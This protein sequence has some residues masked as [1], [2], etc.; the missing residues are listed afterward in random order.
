M[1]A[2]LAHLFFGLAPAQAGPP[3]RGVETRGAVLYSAI[4]YANP[5]VRWKRAQLQLEPRQLPQPVAC[6]QVFSDT[7]PPNDPSQPIGED[8]LALNVWAPKEPGPH[9]VIFFV[10]GGGLLMGSGLNRF[11]DG[12]VFARRGIVFVAINYRLGELGYGPRLDSRPGSLGLLDLEWTVKNVANFGGDP[13]RIYLM[14]QSKGAEAVG[15]LLETGLADDHVK[16]A[17]ALSGPRHFELGSNRFLP[18][19]QQV[20]YPGET[21]QSF[22]D[23][24]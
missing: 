13:S 3:F 11:Y 10:H 8:C 16:G 14:G 4:A 18:L 12:S 21:T 20:F 19:G 17:I 9:P 15:A 6:P 5:P 24:L 1:L 22:R 2:L 7:F 23:I